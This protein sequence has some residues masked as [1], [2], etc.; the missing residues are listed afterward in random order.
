MDDLGL[1]GRRAEL[2]R[3]ERHLGVTTGGTLVALRGPPGIGKTALADATAALA[4]NRG[5]AVAWA[6]CA[7]GV[8]TPD[9]WPWTQIVR[10][11]GSNELP[12][13]PTTFARYDAVIRTLQDRAR[14]QPLLLTFDDL[15]DADESSLELFDLLVRQRR[16]HQITLVATARLDPRGSV[17]R[18]LRDADTIEVVGLDVH[19]VTDLVRRHRDDLDHDELDRLHQTTGGNPF[20]VLELT[21]VLDR[22]SDVAADRPLPQSVLDVVGDHLDLVDDATRQTL[23]AAAVLG[24]HFS[25][26]LLLAVLADR[27]AAELDRTLEAA[28]EAGLLVRSAPHDA[29]SHALIVD[30]L[31]QGMDRRT[32]V[33]LHR[34][35]AAVS[36]EPETV[37]GHLISAGDA[38]E[39]HELAAAC[40]RAAH[41]AA[42][43]HAAD[44][45]ARFLRAALDVAIR[46]DDDPLTVDLLLEHATLAKAARDLHGAAASAL[47]AARRARA[48]G[49]DR[50]LVRAALVMPPDSES[51]EVDQLT[52]DAQIELREEAL[53]RLP[54]DDDGLAARL[55]ASLATSLYWAQH[56][57]D[58]ALDHR[59]TAL[60]R[61]Q[62]TATA[63][64]LARADGCTP[65]V[66]FCIAARLSA[67]WGP[68]APTDRD[69]LAAEL[70][71]LAEA[72]GDGELLLQAYGWRVVLALSAG[73]H[74][75]ASAAIT[76]HRRLA[77]RRHD[78]VARWTSTRWQASLAILEGRIDEG[79]RLAAVALEQGR[80]AVG[81]RAAAD[82]Y[83]VQIGLIQ[84][85][86]GRLGAS[87]EVVR[88]MADD[89]AH[90]PA[91]RCGLV[92]TAV[93]AGELDVASRELRS[94]AVDDF[95]ALPR[96]LDWL[97]SLVILAPAARAV[98]DRETA[99]TLRELLAEHA[100]AHALVGLGYASYGPVRRAMAC[101][102]QTLGNDDEAIEHLRLGL[103][104]LDAAHV[105]YD[106]ILRTEL[107]CALERRG[108]PADLAEARGLL[109]ELR[110]VLPERQLS[111]FAAQAD[112]VSERLGGREAAVL[113]LD[114]DAWIVAAPGGETHRLRALRGLP[115]LH[116]LLASEE[117]RT[118]LELLWSVEP[119]EDPDALSTSGLRAAVAAERGAPL[120]DERAR[121]AYEGR[122]ADLDEQ[123]ARAD[124]LG[125]VDGSA[126]VLAERARLGEELARATGFGRRPRAGGDAS[127]RARTSVTKSLRRA[128]AAIAEA[129]P[130][131]GAHLDAAVQTGARC[132]YR[133]DPLDRIDWDLG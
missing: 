34:A 14:D 110:T 104:R 83:A 116:A 115:L 100:D 81:R 57:G 71:V 6:S 16:D 109:T 72:S 13:A 28:T 10:A 53:A 108:S 121:Q 105:V 11:L 55:M 64:N 42:S 4:R 18:A 124:R 77:E 97:S 106:A 125:D 43:R 60:R 68:D 98:G 126:E 133:P 63:L 96:D 39:P 26:T 75:R 5:F 95:A 2:A 130:S 19:G 120:I 112:A 66:S 79:E 38:T 15:H 32:R 41:A 3:L 40:R 118:P 127:E 74:A 132:A 61:D 21:R 76:D 119:P 27:S 24:Q 69:E 86:Q 101:I 131:L 107:A 58:R 56:T 20:F 111:A 33:Q 25:R 22:G 78:P 88:A 123:L 91:W 51:I 54:R 44:E 84:W 122:I 45:G 128:I 87:F 94:L 23:E 29:F 48:M 12:E 46:G 65:V 59:A 85:L 90:V 35:V 8:G 80:R 92:W 89:A 36:T 113:K 62:L 102:E 49:D 103:E 9:L 70:T 47:E 50:R 114:H 7:A 93:E 99:A 129:E 73:D 17:D 67:L 37:A 117:E 31:L 82:F 30:V 1:V 52:D